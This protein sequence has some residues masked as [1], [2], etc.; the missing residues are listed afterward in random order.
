MSNKIEISGSI[1]DIEK[2]T[3]NDGPGIRTTVFFKGC[4]LYCEWCSN[5][6]TISIEDD[7]YFKK[8]KCTECMN[9]INV[10][11]VK[12]I[13]YRRGIRINREKCN[14]CFK[15]CEICLDKAL[16]KVGFKVK[17]E[18]LTEIL[19]KDIAFYENEGGV[20]FSGGE[21]ML[22]AEFLL[23]ILKKCKEN[24]LHVVLDTSGYAKSDYV[25]SIVK[26]VDLTLLDIKHMNDD[27]HK[28]GTGVSNRIILENAKI[29][30]KNTNTRISVPIIPG[31]NDDE[32]NLKRTA[33][34]AISLN[35]KNVDVILFH[36]YG[37]QKYNY[38]G[39]PSLFNKYKN[40]Y[41]KNHINNILQIFNERSIHT[42]LGR[43]F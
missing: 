42:T 4:P 19:L 38:L 2:Y 7:L 12:A 34:F 27:K 18:E 39:K 10:C 11:E 35:V 17:I 30:A 43:N 32:L 24:K 25:K 22:Q 13:K 40:I 41:N 29:F 28:D 36:D 15:C 1:A 5:P 8:S 26:Y 14:K 33:E 9:C 21:P 3:V 20:T 6:E 31:F 16:V 23:E 37:E